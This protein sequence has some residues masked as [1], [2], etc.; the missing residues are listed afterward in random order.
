[1]HKSVIQTIDWQ[2]RFF[3]NRSS[4]KIDRHLL[5]GDRSASLFN[6]PTPGDT[7]VEAVLWLFC[8]V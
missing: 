1:M 2:R 8:E 5:C 3:C 4:A 6:H 7:L